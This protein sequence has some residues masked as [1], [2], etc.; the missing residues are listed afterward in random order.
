M[1][2][3]KP[4]T[5]I[6]LLAGAFLLSSCDKEEVITV[7]IDFEEPTAGAVVADAADVHIHVHFTATGGELHDVE[8]ILH[9]E[10]DASDRIIEF[11]G[12]D[13]AMEYAFMEDVNLSGYPSGSSF[14]LEAKA[15]LDHDCADSEIGE[16]TFSIP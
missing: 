10:N 7:A 1:Q 5:L 14:R 15:C 13:H 9:P 2:N 3:I 4:I 8:V 6:F 11:D 16:I 12:H